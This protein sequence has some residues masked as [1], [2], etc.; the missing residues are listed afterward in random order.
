M[1]DDDEGN[2]GNEGDEDGDGGAGENAGEADGPAISQT[3][4][5]VRPAL[6]D[7]ADAEPSDNEDNEDDEDDD[8]SEVDASLD[9]DDVEEVEE[10]EAP[11]APP[12]RVAL[13][14]APA[15]APMPP[16]PRIPSTM[17]GPGQPV[18]PPLPPTPPVRPVVV[19]PPRV[20]SPPAGLSPA[21]GGVVR[22][23][24]VL[25]RPPVGIPPRPAGAPPLSSIPPLAIPAPATSVP[26]VPPKDKDVAPAEAK[27]TSESVA[28]RMRIEIPPAA[29]RPTDPD[30]DGSSRRSVPAMIPDAPARRSSPIVSPDAAARR[31]SP[32]VSPD[33]EARR[34]TPAMEPAPDAAPDAVPDAGSAAPSERMNR[35]VVRDRLAE[36]G[37]EVNTETPRIVETKPIEAH[38]ESPTVVERALADLG[39]SGG[40]LRAEELMV[41]LEAT[42]DPALAAM[43]A[44]EL[45][46]LYE[47]RLADEARAVKAYGRALTLDPSLRA[48]L[49]SIRRVF[50]RR[51]LWPNLV[52]LIAAEV[53]YA[54]DDAERADL[55]L[56][57]ARVAQRIDGA[58]DGREALEEAVRIAPQHQGAL[59]ELERVLA[60]AGDAAALLDVWEWLAEAVEIPARKISY[61][62]DVGRAAAS[63]EY[64]RAQAAFEQA[65]ALA[66]GTPASAERVAR[67]RLRAAEEH[68]TP[69]DVSAALEELAGQLLAAFGPAGPAV[70]A[71]I[72]APAR[73]T[74]L[75]REVVALRRRQAQLVRA[76]APEKAWDVLQQGLALASG[77][78]LLLADL[79]ELAEELGRYDDLAELVQSWQAV[80]GDPG[81]AMVLSIRRADALLRGGQRDQARALLAGLEATAPGFIVL[82]SAAERDALGRAHPGDLARTYIAAAHAALLGSWL[83]P[84][85]PPAPDPH[86]AAALYVQAAE[87]FAYEV[88]A[89]D[90]PPEAPNPLD[91]ARSALTK[92]LE[93]VPNYPPALE[94][95]TELDDVTGNIAEGLERL[96]EA[97]MAADGDSR[98][99]LLERAIRLARGHGDL[100][101]VL[102]LERTLAALAPDD[103]SLRWRLESTLS[104]LGRDEERAELLA[105][106]AAGEGD[107]T[108]RGTALL[109]AARLRERAGAVESATELYRRVLALW[110]DD[111]FARESLID[112]LR[113]QERWTELVSERS[114]EARA[115]P[116]GAA[117][118]RAL[119]EAA[120]VLEVRLGETAEAARIYDEWLQR[121]GD[122]RTALEGA[123]RCRALLGDRMGESAARRVLADLEPT[124]EGQWLY[125]RA[126]E[127]ADQLD[128]AADVYRALMVR[129]EPSVAATAAAFGLADI[130]AARVDTVMRVEA[131]AALAARTREPRLGAALAEDSGWMYALVLEDFERAAQSFA[132]ATA[133]DPT[134]RG[135]L[136]GAALVA[137][138]QNEPGALAAAYEGLAATVQMAEA[139]AA[140]HL[141]AAAVAAATG[142]VELANARVA[143]ARGAAP[144]DTS[145][146]LVVA[147]AAALPVVDAADP[148]AAIDPLLARAEVLEMRSA[149]ADDPAARATWELDRAE[150]LELAGRLREAGTVVAAVLGT[151][152]DDLRA[153]EA[154][155]RMARR[156]GD[157]VGWAQASYQLAR[158]LGDPAAKLAL[159]RDAAGV[160]DAP[161]ERTSVPPGPLAEMARQRAE[162]ALAIYRRILQVDPGAP[163]LERLLDLLR[164]RA[165]VRGLIQALTERLTWLE[166]EAQDLARDQQMVPLLLERATVLH[167]LGDKP[168]AMVDLDALL[169]RAASHAEALRFR[170]DLAFEAGDVE[171][172][173]SL[174]RRCLTAETRPQRRGEIELQLAKVL[175][176][177]V[178]DV[179]GAI[180]NLEHFA[181]SNPDD[182]G[183]REQILALCLRAN[184]WERAVRE[185]KVLARLRPTP[186]D[187]A[188]EELRLGL[189]YRDRLNDRT[190][191]RLALDRA[192]ALDPLN[193]DVIRE[194]S[195]LLESGSRGQVLAATA[196]S[197]RSSI[198]QN[199]KSAV[200]YDRLAQ[201]AAW[202]SDVD[203]RWLALVGLEALGTLSVDQRQ[204][205]EQGR[206]KVAA[207]GRVKLDPAARKLL[208]GPAAGPL[209]DLWRAIAPAAQ[210][211][212][213]VDPAKLGFARGDRL[214]IKKLGDRYEALATALACFGIEE[215]EIYIG[216]SRTGSAWAL[217]AETPILCIGADVAAG[218]T[219]QQR[220]IIG[221]TVAMIAEGFATLPELRE[222]EL[223]WTIAAALRA[224]EVAI[225]PRLAEEIDVDNASIADRVRL[226]RK[227]LSRKERA[228]VQQLA[229]Q[230]AAELVD[231]AGFRRQ[232]LAAGNRSG[233]VWSGDLAVSLAQLD[234]VRGGKA[235]I[236]NAVALDL[237]AWSVSEEHLRLREIL[238]IG[239]KGAR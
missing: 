88:A 163:E 194:L 65:A 158:V 34:S 23:P 53:D 231:V 28:P 147:E 80:E 27:S 46:E 8:G 187:K 110:P 10:D 57:K 96:R 161:A 38:L 58:D 130:A 164:R 42:P 12:P 104:Q 213:G 56:E 90:R 64:P 120:W 83:G 169:D 92:A 55:L 205:L 219:P 102:D 239:L 141:R 44:Y 152:P 1:L 68:G 131:T 138:K 71:D 212:T 48:N 228:T 43:V 232:A 195:E 137:A 172:A 188:R 206:Q 174:W 6:A 144:D 123:A 39:E 214:A 221:R 69:E 93:A 227:E 75:R 175:A 72:E 165:D 86:A 182:V 125:A 171:L 108:R 225:P 230:R 199:P 128:D 84:G 203:G 173:I 210:V 99:A 63:R 47:R 209:F 82:T 91:E 146:L 193:L 119:R 13:A 170:A 36:G 25:P 79:T 222:A 117:A 181:E 237:A 54:R 52:K 94:A 2:E 15:P 122:D 149:L 211:A 180:E 66:A 143:A 100:E 121:F 186:Q 229:Q 185:L 30:A 106:I 223:G 177:N 21:P 150:A 77:E 145:A 234:V 112:L 134:R 11:A 41:E 45:G 178:N 129:E 184:D 49:W 236:D 81:R 32:I 179:A 191:S 18:A 9:M 133:L 78:P 160:F 107:A 235:L 201:V 19:V 127:R 61:W 40:E 162:M 207:P 189:M 226:I 60:R 124:P 33:A 208:R 154:M 7:A 200:L 132:A 116:D 139:A 70:G 218:K 20:P 16:P 50:Y 176:E 217:A 135:A 155:R 109:A 215:L 233:L 157:L 153:L 103:L 202:Q 95:L 136:L 183:L 85:Q 167:G 197:F 37:L 67:E 87:L 22:V 204:V 29:P 142:D 192:R 59:L 140:L 118:R 3:R 14:P 196:A 76:D 35:P 159:L 105:E 24:P 89:A 17:R 97:A 31:S 51:G 4:I 148:E 168:A 101:G 115:L 5:D 62:L 98:R 113:A 126:L 220:W 224:A 111:T 166:A 216:T 190:S 26:A 74:Q 238:G 151:Q 114:A 156:A 198:A 73:A